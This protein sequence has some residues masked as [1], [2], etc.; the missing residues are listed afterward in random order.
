MLSATRGSRA[1]TRQAHTAESR[2]NGARRE[3]S[4]ERR[5]RIAWALRRSAHDKRL[6]LALLLVEGLS[7]A[8]AATALGVSIQRVRGFYRE[9]LA[10][11]RAAALPGVRERARRAP[12]AVE[13]FR[14]AS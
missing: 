12:T 4:A 11:L 14:K 8:E 1:A 6:V 9:T 2:E 5:A 10:D 7:P 13:R 3:T